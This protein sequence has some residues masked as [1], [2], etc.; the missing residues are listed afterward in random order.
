MAYNNLRKVSLFLK[1]HFWWQTR[2]KIEKFKAREQ[3]GQI[4]TLWAKIG[5]YGQNWIKLHTMD[6]NWTVWT[7][8][9]HYEQNRRIWTK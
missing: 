9:G 1:V 7:K 3:F 6:K 8:I 2:L 4:W 5:Q